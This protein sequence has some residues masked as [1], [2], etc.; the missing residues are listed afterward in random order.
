MPKARPPCHTNNTFLS[1]VHKTN[2]TKADF[3]CFIAAIFS[4]MITINKKKVEIK[5]ISVHLQFS[6]ENCYTANI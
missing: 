1:V 2:A 5:N 3:S 6:A 4:T